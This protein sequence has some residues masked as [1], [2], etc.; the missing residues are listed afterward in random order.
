MFPAHV[1]VF[2]LSFIHVH[3]S[4]FL[5]NFHV[6]V[7]LHTC[8]ISFKYLFLFSL[9]GAHQVECCWILSLVLKSLSV[10]LNTDTTA[11]IVQVVLK[12]IILPDIVKLACKPTQLNSHWNLSDLEVIEW[13]K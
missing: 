8:R 3:V 10:L 5:F 2:S 11:E 1:H 6:D 9:G 7:N 12:A 13:S 4:V